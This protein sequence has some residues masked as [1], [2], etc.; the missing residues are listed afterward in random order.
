MKNL[1]NKTINFLPAWTTGAPIIGVALLGL[2]YQ[3]LSSSLVLLFSLFL[4]LSVLASVHH[5]EV[6]A[7]KV[8]EPYG[9]L[10]LAMAVT[11]IE[12][13]LIIS[14]MQANPTETQG[15]ARDTVFA[16]IMIILNGIL[17]ICMLLG[18]LKHFEQ[19]FKI[20][21]AKAALSALITIGALT[22]LL[23]NY[24]TTVE[25][26]SFSS[27]QLIFISMSSLV[28]YLG[29]VFVQTVRHRDYFLP[30][31]GAI[32]NEDHHAPK[33]SG[34]TTLVSFALLVTALVAVVLLAKKL[35]PTLEQFIVNKGAPKAFVGVIIALVV[36]LPEG[37]AAIKAAAHNRLQTS[38]NLALG[39]ALATIGLTIPVV[40]ILS[41]VFEWHLELGLSQK[42]TLLLTLSFF[43]SILSLSSRKTNILQGI[44]HL[45]IFFVFI[46]TALIP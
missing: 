18:A 7:H 45:V 35:A 3:E 10:I 39:S 46:I 31:E 21:G 25:G 14:M 43:I 6:I 20:D 9:T 32:S 44:I 2:S 17:G 24:T 13:A 26:A 30:V 23:P 16:A 36:L 22:I 34:K 33:P 27:T 5:A 1:I 28:I 40:A 38:L 42:E 4:F 29:F 41:L 12:T 11:V 37:L 19:E 15:L 8:G